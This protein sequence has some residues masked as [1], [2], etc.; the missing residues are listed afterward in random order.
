MPVKQKKVAVAPRRADDMART[1][2]QPPLGSLQAKILKQLAK[3]GKD[4]YAYRVLG[5][6]MRE[7]QGY[8]DPAQVYTSMRSMSERKLIEALPEP[9][10]D[11]RGPPQKIYKVTAAGRE[12][13]R[14]TKAYHKALFDYL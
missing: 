8:I 2:D 12:A 6:L 11:S 1:R 14:L 3:L 10:Y 5:Q 4:A 9:R 7:K 13:L